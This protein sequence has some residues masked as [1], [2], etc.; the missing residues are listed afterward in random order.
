MRGCVACDRSVVSVQEPTKAPRSR[1][2]SK[3]VLA[4][5][6]PGPSAHQRE[7]GHAAQRARS[8]ATTSPSNAP[9]AAP[10]VPRPRSPSTS[11]TRPALQTLPTLP[12]DRGAAHAAAAAAGAT[13]VAHVQETGVM[14]R[15]VDEFVDRANM[16][17]APSLDASATRVGYSQSYRFA[18]NDLLQNPSSVRIPVPRWLHVTLWDVVV[19]LQVPRWNPQAGVRGGD[20]D[21]RRAGACRAG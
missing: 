14:G 10:F 8:P 9:R 1:S 2:P 16:S 7:N 6:R 17:P 4:S 11:P 18:R 3:A 21:H 12:S 13:M 15:G 5:S 20:L 19:S